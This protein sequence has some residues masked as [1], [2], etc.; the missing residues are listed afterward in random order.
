MNN[1]CCVASTGFAATKDLGDCGG[2]RR[3]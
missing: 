2:L 3:V 1:Y